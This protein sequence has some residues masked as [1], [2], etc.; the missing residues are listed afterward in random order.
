MVKIHQRLL[1]EKKKKQLFTQFHK[2]RQYQENRGS[3][4][5]AWGISF[6]LV[7][8]VI[9]VYLCNAFT[10]IVPCKGVRQWKLTTETQGSFKNWVYVDG[11]SKDLWR[12][13]TE[14]FSM[15]RLSM[16]TPLLFC[17]HTISQKCPH[18]FGKG[19]CKHTRYTLYNTGHT[20]TPHSQSVTMFIGVGR[21]AHQGCVPHRQSP[22][23]T[24]HHVLKDHFRTSV[25]AVP[26]S[27]LTAEGLY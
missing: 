22:S 24:S 4:S 14:P 16:T 3:K 10:H 1:L 19:P 11:S 20:S 23:P 6:S 25:Q 27:K 12:E 2:H 17:S 18:V 21:V 7:W 13:L 9:K 26:G 8:S 15:M 5:L